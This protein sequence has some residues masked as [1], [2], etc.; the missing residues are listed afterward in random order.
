MKVDRSIKLVAGIVS[1]VLLLFSK[2]PFSLWPTYSTAASL[3]I[4]FA[5]VTPI[6]ICLWGSF[7][8]GASMGAASTQSGAG[9]DARAGMGMFGVGA[10]E[11]KGAVTLLWYRYVFDVYGGTILLSLKLAALCIVITMVLGVFGGYR[12]DTRFSPRCG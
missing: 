9:W 6:L 7:T 2:R 8:T 3:V 4:V 5:V 11:T 1:T 12:P 10:R